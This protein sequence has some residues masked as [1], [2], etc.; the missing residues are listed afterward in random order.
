VGVGLRAFAVALACVVSPTLG[1]AD[2]I[3]L[4]YISFDNLVPGAPGSPGVNGFTIGDLTGDSA[5]VRDA[6]GFLEAFDLD[7]P[8]AGTQL[9]PHCEGQF[10]TSDDL[11]FGIWRY[12]GSLGCRRADRSQ[13]D[14]TGLK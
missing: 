3:R 4:G 10:P 5:V 13:S 14:E 9:Q 11:D 2:T 12:V 7:L 6:P 8:G 1:R